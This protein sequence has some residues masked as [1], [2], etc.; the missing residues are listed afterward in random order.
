MERTI[1]R[2]S[3][4]RSNREYKDS[5]VYRLHEKQ[6]KKFRYLNVFLNQIIIS[7]LIILLILVIDYF[8][9]TVAKEWIVTNFSNGYEFSEVF[10]LIKSRFENNMVFKSGDIDYDSGENSGDILLDVVSGEKVFQTA[11]EGINQMSEDAKFIKENYDF[12]LPLK[13][14]V[15]SEF[16]CRVSTNN[17]VSSYHTGLDIAANTGTSIVAAHNGKVT[18]ARTFSSY[19]KSI[20]VED[21]DLVTVY[22]HCSS[23][24]IKEG[25]NVNKGDLIGKVGMTGNATGP[26]LHFEIRY[27]D[28]FVNPKDVLGEI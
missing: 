2:T 5:N 22:A 21:G 4:R 12:I 1:D 27:E 11:V 19:G 10:S 23:I 8:D 15:T 6:T 28:R 17:L 9:I 20:M 3:Y 26:H 14:I 13:G 18:L 25:Q 16:G 24:N 7:L